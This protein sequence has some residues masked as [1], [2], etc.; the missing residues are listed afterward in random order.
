[1]D[2]GTCAVGEVDAVRVLVVGGAMHTLGR[3]AALRVERA[4]GTSEVLV[5][6]DPYDFDWQLIYQFAEPVRFNDG[7]ELSLA[8]T[9]DNTMGEADVNW[10]EGTGEEM[11][12]ANLFLSELP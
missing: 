12:V 4:D 1:M 8:C 11:C 6:V 9:F 3:H 5:E 7:D 2:A 10:G